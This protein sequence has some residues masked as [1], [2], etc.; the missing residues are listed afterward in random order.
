MGSRKKIAAG[1]TI[2]CAFYLLALLADFLSA[3]DYRDQGRREPLA[4]P[5]AVHFRDREGR[6]HLRPFV[7]PR[8]LADPLRRRYEEDTSR[9]YPLAFFARGHRYKFLGLFEADRHL[10]GLQ[11]A[12]ADDTAAP[13]LY[14]LGT[15]ASGRDR[16]A[17]LLRAARFTLTVGPAGTLLACLLGVAVG[18]LSGYAGRAL[19]A[20]LMRAA[21]TLMA[22]PTLVI[23]LAAR[24]AF[25]LELPPLRAAALL[26]LIFVVT[27]WAEMAR[28]ARG[29]ILSLRRREF[30]L[31]AESL[32]L[33]RARILFRH[34]LPNASGPLLVQAALMLPAFLLAETALS[35]LGV[36]V[37]EPEPSWGQ[38]L[39]A[40]A[41]INLLRESPLL[42]LAPALCI[43]LFVLGVRLL[44]DG[45][46]ERYK[47]LRT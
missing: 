46:R 29:L 26:V 1:A 6:Y 9:A 43:F 2:V 22:L 30:V 33:T 14:L 35:F 15:D 12:K 21:D 42:L 37:Q 27:G 40:A 16:L 8:R 41:D 34:V 31:A 11:D 5:T 23:I 44:G 13:R 32:G 39:A 38:M 36:G 17:R 20:L 3:N 24:A 4:P 10:V 18:C 28:L 25:P 47:N 45:L 19:D 7:H